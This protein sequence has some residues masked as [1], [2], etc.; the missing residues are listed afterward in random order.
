MF[1]IIEFENVKSCNFSI[2]PLNALR[3][4]TRTRSQ[5]VLSEGVQIWLF[6]LFFLL[7]SIDEGTEDQ[8][9]TTNGPSWAR[10]Q[11]AI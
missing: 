4:D 5:E 11:K 6:S 8:N 3:R 2:L 7:F 1:S 10:Q 9:T